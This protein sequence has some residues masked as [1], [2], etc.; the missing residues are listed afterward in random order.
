M[1]KRFLLKS[2]AFLAGI[3]FILEFFLP[4]KIGGDFDSHGV[5]SPVVI[6][7]PAGRHLLYTGQY[8]DRQAAIGLRFEPAESPGQWQAPSGRP[9][10]QRSLF[11]PHDKV[12][13]QQL[14]AVPLDGRVALFYLGLNPA[15]ERTLCQA[16]GDFRNG[17][18]RKHAPPRFLPA[19]PPPPADAPRAQPNGPL[20]GSLQH[21][22]VARSDDAW[23]FLLVMQVIGEGTAVWEAEGSVLDGLHLNPEPLYRI[24]D[25]AIELAAFDARR[26]DG[27]WELLLVVERDLIVV[28]FDASGEPTR[29]PPRVLA[30]EATVIT[31]LRADGEALFVSTAQAIEPAPAIEFPAF[32]TRIM[33]L[34][35]LNAPPVGVLEP[36]ARPTPTYLSRGRSQAGV[37]LQVIGVMAL[38][39]PVINL[40]LFHGKRMLRREPGWYNSI[41]F[42]VCLVGM[43]M[44]TMAGR[45]PGN[46]V[47][48]TA[49]AWAQTYHFLFRGIIQ[50]MGT[51]VFSMITFFMISAAYRSFRARNTEAALL[52]L[53]ACVVMLGQVPIGEL[54]GSLLPDA[55]GF[56]RLPWMSQKLLTVINACAFRGVLIGLTVGA[57]SI[58]VRI[59]LGMDDSVYAGLEG[60]E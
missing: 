12:G 33:E 23:R 2:L 41:I 6:S 54:Q 13:M 3:Y 1:N 16:T 11:I 19:T 7:H 57:L 48:A 21:F 38:F 47:E 14:A 17:R 37:F 60:R 35:E 39:I 45:T 8:R 52:M 43:F 20:P 53:S 22:A 51:A 46:D 50:S 44:A 5:H 40:S 25:M 30:P 36:G 32:E 31:G 49:S 28:T 27:N 42:F 9:V 59:W 4:E 26:V 34:P 15:Q 10:L 24:S 18:W 58:A 56:L 29:G 55:L